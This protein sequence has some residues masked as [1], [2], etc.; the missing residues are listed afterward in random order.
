VDLSVETATGTVTIIG[1][2]SNNASTQTGIRVTFDGDD[3]Y[4]Q[5]SCTVTFAPGSEQ[6][7][8]PGKVWGTL[9]CAAMVPSGESPGGGTGTSSCDGSAV[10]VFEFCN[11]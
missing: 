1:M 7:V 10:F 11:Q 6:G 8:Y 2:M 5:T 4:G 9:A 3:A